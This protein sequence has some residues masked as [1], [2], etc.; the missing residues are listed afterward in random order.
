M[1]SKIRKIKFDLSGYYFLGLVVLVLLGFWPTY[2]SKFFDKTADFT[3]YFHFHA[4][5]LSLWIL[6][7]IIQPILIRKR[8]LAVHRLIGKFTY[9]LFPLMILSVVL[10]AH[11]SHHAD[12][13]DLDTNLFLSFKDLV[14]LSTG[15]FIGVRYRHNVDLHARGMV[16][17]G[18][19]CIEPSVVRFLTHAVGDEAIAFYMTI[20]VVYTV[21]VVLI[22]LER[23]QK[24]GR[25]VFPL[26]LCL[27]LLA[28]SAIV[29]HIH[30]P[31]WLEFCKWFLSTRLT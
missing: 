24:R 10:L 15:Y 31:P 4:I 29:F 2:F 26:I 18:I 20:S 13:K 16:V 23:R 14:I 21:L 5:M 22:V 11:S 25:W 3:M 19:V 7:L 12:E 8:K 9:V 28:H 27:Y 17:T 1:E 6:A 30:F